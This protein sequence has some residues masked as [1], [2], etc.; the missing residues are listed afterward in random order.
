MVLRN[1]DLGARRPHCSWN[2]ISSRLCHW[3]ESKIYIRMYT[4]S[5]TYI[6]TYISTCI[7]WNRKWWVNTDTSIGMNISGFIL[8]FTLCV[9]LPFQRV[10]K[11]VLF[12][13]IYSFDLKV[14][15]L[16]IQSC[17]TLYNPTDSLPGSSIHGILQARLL[18]W[19]AIP[20]SRGSFQPRDWTQVSCIAGRFFTIWATREALFDLYPYI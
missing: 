5:L 1:Q 6:H 10:R 15:V 7:Y 20:F 4:Q 17:P 12:A 8:G 18:E 11:W 2:D 9:Q 14:K 3:V 13:L 16:V 19:F